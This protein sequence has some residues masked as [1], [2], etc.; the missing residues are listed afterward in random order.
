MAIDIVYF[1]KDEL[2]NEE[3]RYSLRSVEKNL[4]HRKVWFYGGCPKDI[5][6]DK[7]VHVEQIGN[8]KYNRVSNMIRLA[9]ENDSITEDFYLFNDDFFV[10]IPVEDIPPIH[11]YSLYRHIVEIEDRHDT[12]PTNYSRQLR[13]CAARLSEKEQTTLNYAL[14]YPLKVNRAK[15][16]ETLECF[17]DCPM[18]RSLYGNMH[19]IGGVYSKDCKVKIGG[20]YDPESPFL[21]TTNKSFRSNPVGD[22]IRQSF[23]E[24]CRFEITHASK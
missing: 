12:T 8:T 19:Q 4:P 23:P 11:G 17:P 3:L 10:M 5:K 16:L 9:C 7:H 24:P 1:L 18:F 14:H 21:S 22:F 2:I 15:A 20:T 13:K 6:P